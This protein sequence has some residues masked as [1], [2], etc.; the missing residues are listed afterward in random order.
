M[1]QPARRVNG[2]ASPS[3]QPAVIRCAI[4]TRKSTE[5]GL[6]RD[7]NSL[8]VQRQAC[9]EYVRS[10]AAEGWQLVAEQYDD[11]GWSG[12][13][14][15]RPGFQRL[16]A[17]VEAGRVQCVV[18]HRVDRLSRSLL[19]F[20]RLM[21]FFQERGVAFVSVTQNF[22]T[23]DPVGRLTLNL[24]ATFAEFERE[25]ISARTKDKIAASR[26]RGRWT[27][28]FV[29]LGYDLSDGRLVINEAGAA[30]VGE[31]FAVYEKTGSLTRTVEELSRRGI[32]MRT[33]VPQNGTGN[34]G[35]PYDKPSVLRVLRSPIVAGL[36]RSGE[37]LV[38]A[39]H[40]AIVQLETWQNIQERLT[41]NGSAGYQGERENQHALL[42]G[43]L[44]CT[45]CGCRMSPTYTD[46]GGRR[47]RYYTCQSRIRQGAHACPTGQV[48]ANEIEQR[49]VE[50]IRAIGRDPGLVAETVQQVRL[51][52]D[53]LVATI[54]AEEK[55]LRRELR[56]KRATLK[57]LVT[58]GGS[59]AERKP[60][61]ERIA[62]IQAR[63][64]TLPKEIHAAKHLGIDPHEVAKALEAFGPV[65]EAL[66]PAER[67]RTL[68]LL[69]ES[70]GYDGRSQPIAVRF[71]TGGVGA[72]ANGTA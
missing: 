13:T 9:E 59:Q 67:A 28:G 56:G 4:Y 2:R 11:G 18:V 34:P 12:A 64:S 72:F 20:A 32:A 7:I 71:R 26:R 55:A 38:K 43:L 29:P 8:S 14:V 35:R 46:K 68:G 33:R 31:I 19:D 65:W 44:C 24:L 52:R 62:S 6:D 40:E 16:L 39:E 47:Y 25:M 51:Q 50:Q 58:K 15:K 49:V 3:T 30:T 37:A 1:S 70:V 36:I 21:A 54:K 17:D 5:E 10:R 42:K 60:L 66:W 41:R 22:S 45:A 57:R 61:E 69:V 23:A 63:L 48:A 27:G 53:A